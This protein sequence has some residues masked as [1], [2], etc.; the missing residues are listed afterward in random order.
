MRGSL[1]L[2]YENYGFYPNSLTDLLNKRFTKEAEVGQKTYEM[3]EIPKEYISK[4]NGSNK[5]SNI[6][7][8]SGGWYYDKQNHT[9]YINLNKP[10]KYYLRYYRGKYSEERPSNW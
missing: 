3:K 6:L 10:I 2:F 8:G 9:V 5:V 7:D 4:K 1:L